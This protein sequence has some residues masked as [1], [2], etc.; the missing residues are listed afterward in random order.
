[1]NEWF[2]WNG[3]NNMQVNSWEDMKEKYPEYRCDMS[4]ER[5]K[6]FVSDCFDLYEK[7]GFNKVFWSQGGDYKQYHGKSFDVIGRVP[8]YDGKNDGADLECLPMWNI[9]FEDGLV[10]SAYADEIV[11]REMKDNGCPEEYIKG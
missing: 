9:Q 11:T 1:M 6:E 2:L 4:E 5:E 3:G 10:V 8:I 7:E